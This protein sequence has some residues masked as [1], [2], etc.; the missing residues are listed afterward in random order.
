M[1][2]Q[3]RR[4]KAGKMPFTNLSLPNAVESVNRGGL[5]KIEAMREAASSLDKTWPTPA[6][7]YQDESVDSW[8][9]RQI[10]R[11]KASKS[12]YE[13]SLNVLAENNEASLHLLKD[14]DLMRDTEDLIL[15]IKQVMNK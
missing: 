9:R 7:G 11:A 15:E 5:D 3:G 4:I 12:T 8:L 6:V 2:R 10:E 1:N 13:A 14:L